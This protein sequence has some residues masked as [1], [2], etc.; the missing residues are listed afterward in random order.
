MRLMRAGLNSTADAAASWSERFT[1]AY[2][3]AQPLRHVRGMLWHGSPRIYY[4]RYSD[5]ALRDLARSLRATVRAGS[6]CW[7]IFDNTAG[8]HA[9]A[10]AARL[11]AL[12]EQ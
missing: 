6:A 8:G 7:C 2:H 5:D 1:L 12:L 9:M 3:A 10:D 11:Q 4:S